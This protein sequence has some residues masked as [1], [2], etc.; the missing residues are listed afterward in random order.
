MAEWL[1]AS[2][3]GNAT[4]AELRSELA[5]FGII[6][7]RER[8]TAWQLIETVGSLLCLR[9]LGE[10]AL[11]DPETDAG[12]DALWAG[13]L[14]RAERIDVEDEYV[15]RELRTI[16]AAAAN[17]ICFVNLM[18]QPQKRYVSVAPTVRGISVCAVYPCGGPPNER[19]PRVISGFS[20]KR[21]FTKSEAFA[22]PNW[23]PA[24]NDSRLVAG[25]RRNVSGSGG[26]R[27]G[28]RLAR[29]NAEISSGP[30]E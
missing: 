23:T 2:G 17:A 22:P 13:L 6:A 11:V 26:G 12:D 14:R 29:F 3:L 21:F 25:A 30:F 1:T 28:D 5:L 7:L 18:A 24:R 19:S 20:L 15:L 27:T 8:F 16:D 9:R 4:P 10:R